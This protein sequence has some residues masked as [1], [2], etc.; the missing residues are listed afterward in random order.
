[1]NLQDELNKLKNIDI[2]KLEQIIDQLENEK[3]YLI[4]RLEEQN[5]KI[6]EQNK[7]IDEHASNIA[8]LNSR[9]DSIEEM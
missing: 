5:K 3:A 2:K 7:K 6:D 9:I 8:S 4:K 1:M